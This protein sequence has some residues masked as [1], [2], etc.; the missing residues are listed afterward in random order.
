VP[1]NAND[2]PSVGAGCSLELLGSGPLANPVGGHG[3]LMSA[4]A[5]AA[6][7]TGFLIV[8]REV[9]GSSARL[10]LLPI[11]FSGGALEAHRPRLPDRCPDSDETD[12]VGLTVSGNHAMIALARPP[13]GEPALLEL[14]N[15]NPTTLE[16][17][18]FVVSR[19]QGNVR[20]FF[21]P[22]RGAA[23]RNA[24]NVAV[25][26]VGDATFAGTMNPDA[27]IMEPVGTFG[28]TSGMTGAWVATSD[29]VLALLA[30]GPGGVAPTPDPDGGAPD[31]GELPPPE[32]TG[33]T[34]RLHMLPVNQPLDE[35]VASEN[36]PRTPIPIPGE[37][38]SLAATGSRVIVLSDGGGPGRSVS[39]RAYDLNRDEPAD[40]NGFSVD[41]L[42]KASAG[43]VTIQGDHVYF[44]VLKAGAV[45]LAAY[46]NA[47]TTPAPLRQVSFGKEPRIS[48]IDTI[49]DGYVA[50]AATE[51]RV[52][53]AWTTAKVLTENDG[54]GGYAVFACTP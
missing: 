54:T 11:D 39:F 30:A 24:G 29:R 9:D 53:V 44:A 43:D 18:K 51:T 3:T 35:L 46:R 2:D 8:Y 7:E 37:W 49:R 21:S 32:D 40:T 23:A 42:A 22:A 5:I 45:S 50:V 20:A 34:L 4:P 47:S 48:G 31:G 19:S 25:Y 28:G 33:P 1:A 41:G 26:T 27:G 14:L 6:T 15:L 36:K 13:C 17:G 52:A 10:T 38:G 16:I 12:G